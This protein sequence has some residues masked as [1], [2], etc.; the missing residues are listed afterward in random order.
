M[1]LLIDIWIRITYYCNGET[2]QHLSWVSTNFRKTILLSHLQLTKIEINRLLDCL[3]DFPSTTFHRFLQ[4]FQEIK[5][6]WLKDE[7]QNNVVDIHYQLLI[8][9]LTIVHHIESFQLFCYFTNDLDIDSNANVFLSV[10]ASLNF[11]SENTDLF[12]AFCKM[13]SFL[14]Y[15]NITEFE[16]NQN[17]M[18]LIQNRY[19]LFMTNPKTLI[20]SQKRETKKFLHLHKKIFPSF[21]RNTENDA[22]SL[23]NFFNFHDLSPPYKQNM[24]DMASPSSYLDCRAKQYLPSN[25]QQWNQNDKSKL[26]CLFSPKELITINDI[27]KEDLNLDECPRVLFT[28]GIKTNQRNK[29]FEYLRSSDCK[30]LKKLC[31][32]SQFWSVI[33]FVLLNDIPGDHIKQLYKKCLPLFHIILLSFGQSK[34]KDGLEGNTK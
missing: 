25:F 16:S 9:L 5:N 18:L 24:V 8:G 21:H 34:T 20:Y 28:I 13:F 31:C 26:L 33:E 7:Q 3:I 23:L 22:L 11:V 29:I 15:T 14:V 12:S 2:R 17:V 10:L 32:K 30:D 19:Y 27:S 6:Y 1:N 4:D